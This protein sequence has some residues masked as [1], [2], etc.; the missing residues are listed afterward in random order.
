V[1]VIRIRISVYQ[2]ERLR[3]RVCVLIEMTITYSI[4]NML[5]ISS[6]VTCFL[7]LSSAV[8]GIVA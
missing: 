7:W 2:R 4:S 1:V 8:V 5:A 3:E 6:T